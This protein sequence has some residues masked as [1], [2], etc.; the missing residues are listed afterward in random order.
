MKK[1]PFGVTIAFALGLMLRVV[2]VWRT[3]DLGT[4]ILDE[5]QFVR[6]ASS[7]L[8]GDGFGWGPGDPTSLRPPLYPGVL[9]ALWWATGDGN[10][11]AARMMQILL[12]ALT[13]LTVYLLGRRVFN[14]HVGLVAAAVVWLYPSLVFFNMVMLTETLF[15]LLLTVFLLLAVH[16]VNRPTVAAGLLCGLALGLAAL[17]RSVLWPLPLLLCPVLLVIT[18]GP[19]RARML[20]TAAVLVGFVAPVGPWAVRNTMLQGVPTVVDTMGGM[21]LRMGNYEYT[22]DDRMWD[23]VA[24][25][26]DKSWVKGIETEFAHPPTEGEKE[27]WAQRKALA[28]MAA[29]PGIT[30]RR[31]LIKFA[32]FWGLEREFLAGVARGLYTPPRWFVLPA[33][34]LVA[35]ASAVLMIVGGMGIW[36]ARP[37]YRQHVVLLL[38]IVMITAVH[39]IVFGHSRYHV[40]LMPIFALYG[41]ALVLEPGRWSRSSSLARL[42]AVC[43]VVLLL[44]V[45]VREL[46]IVDAG[47]IRGFFG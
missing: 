37:E 1:L 22:P 39:T 33:S 9:A 38:P 24:L 42:A 34:V 36:L 47:R 23:A 45:W 16:L 20:A 31:A 25:G 6:L 17:T 14:R 2:L 43:T 40:P 30:L 3:A 35:L 5:Q 12:A 7:L 8:R 11:Q 28:Y 44:M 19:F 4:P 41:A 15:T 13:S 46:A 21:N 32:D 27:K 29:H 26:G 10:L 18:R